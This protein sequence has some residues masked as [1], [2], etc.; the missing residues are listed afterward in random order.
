[1][2]TKTDTVTEQV[3][4]DTRPGYLRRVPTRVL[5]EDIRVASYDAALQEM[6]HADSQDPADLKMLV[7]AH[8]RERLDVALELLQREREG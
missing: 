4:M 2:S 8:A 7:L 6:R 1:M 3:E 5:L